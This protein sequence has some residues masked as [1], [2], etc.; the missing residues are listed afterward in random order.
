[1]SEYSCR[2]RQATSVSL[3]LP[4]WVHGVLRSAPQCHTD[5]DKMRFVVQLARTNVMR[6]TGGPFGAAIFRQSDNSLVAVGVNRVEPLHNAI[7]HAE[8]MAIMLAEATVQSYSLRAPGLPPHEL[9]TSCEPCAMCLGA[10]FWSG[11]R[12]LVCGAGRC[13]AASLGFD[14]GPVFPASYR[15]LEARGIQVVRCILADEARGVF[16]LYRQCKGAV[17]NG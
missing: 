15:Y 9:V 11:V 13:D 17:Y 10:T 1:M 16:D 7:L 5:E 6:G 4:R 14:E 8:V 12:R 3:S 2:R